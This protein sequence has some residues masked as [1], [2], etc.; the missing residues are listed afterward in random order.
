MDLNETLLLLSG[1]G[2]GS[3]VCAEVRKVV[4]RT[5]DLRIEEC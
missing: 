3:E 2:I 4:A 1:D 5:P